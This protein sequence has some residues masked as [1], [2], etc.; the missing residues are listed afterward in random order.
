MTIGINETF[1]F[2]EGTSEAKFFNGM[3]K[4]AEASEDRTTRPF[5]L[6]RLE[7]FKRQSGN[8]SAVQ[9]EKDLSGD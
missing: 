9:Q 3:E 4:R 2:A 7:R 1:P 6:L 5:M 8:V